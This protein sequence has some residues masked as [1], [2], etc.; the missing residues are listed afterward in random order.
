[1]E[2]IERTLKYR[3]SPSLAGSLAAAECFLALFDNQPRI[4]WRLSPIHIPG[5]V[6]KSDHGEALVVQVLHVLREPLRRCMHPG[7]LYVWRAMK[8]DDCDLSVLRLARRPLEVV[9]GP[10]RTGVTR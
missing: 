1:M 5:K 9:Q 3:H 7:V 2:Y 4:R 10:D 6:A 8:L